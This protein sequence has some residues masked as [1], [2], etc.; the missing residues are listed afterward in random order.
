[1]GIDRI[2]MNLNI[3]VKYVVDYCIEKLKNPNSLI[4]KKGNNW[5]VK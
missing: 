5:Y 4:Y 3:D 1:M 2:K